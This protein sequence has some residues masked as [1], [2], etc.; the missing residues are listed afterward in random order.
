MSKRV[1]RFYEFGPYRLDSVERLLLYKGQTLPLTL[2][3]FETLFVLIQNNGQL[4]E[5]EQLLENV[6]PDT[7]VQESTLAQNVYML[8]KILGKTSEGDGY[9]KTIPRRGY[10]FIVNVREVEDE[11][12]GPVVPAVAMQ[13]SLCLNTEEG[14][15][16]TEAQG[17]HSLAVLPLINASADQETD[18]LS[19]SISESIISSLAQLVQLR[20]IARSIVF[21]YKGRE[22]D[23]Q[24]VGDELGVSMVLMGRIIHLGCH[25]VCWMELVDV[26]DGSRLWGEQY[27]RKLSD[28]FKVQE[29]I[30]QEVV[31]KVRLRLMG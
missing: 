17:I 12:A 27:K 22:V 16:R 7:F 2:K 18:Y 14:E 9:I 31:Q 13:D 1:F 6:W 11:S 5:K 24:T 3:A 23:P 4:V 21:R 8:R 26:A 25:L 15:S 19:E 20:V 10:R 28:I 29:E 30:A